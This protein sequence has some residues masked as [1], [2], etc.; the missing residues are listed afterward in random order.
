[1]GCRPLG[2]KES[3]VT[4]HACICWSLLFSLF[5]SGLFKTKLGVR[6]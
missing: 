4:E 5:L 6:D 1:M 3:V 2:C